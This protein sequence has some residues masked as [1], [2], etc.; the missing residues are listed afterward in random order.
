MAKFTA[1]A[2]ALLMLPAVLAAG[3]TPGLF[4]SYVSLSIELIGFPQWAGTK[5]NRNEFSNNLID[6]LVKAQE[7]PLVVR[8]GGNSADRAIFDAS[9]TTPT[10][11]SCKNADPGA[12]QCIGP[13]F[14]D[15]Y[16]A[17]PA[18]TRYSHGF[19]LATWNSS[20]FNTLRETV[21]LACR[22]LR[23]QLAYFEV[24]NEPDLYIGSRRPQ[25]YSVAQYVSEWSNATARFE[26]YLREACPDLVVAASDSNSNSNSNS[27][28]NNIKYMFP[29]VSSPRSKLRVPDII[30]AANAAAGGHDDDASIRRVTQV[31]VHN[32]M[33]GATQPGVTLQATLMNHTA[34]AASI[35]RHVAYAA[36]IGGLTPA[37]Y[38]IGEHNS[39]YGGGAA[40]LSD[41]FGAA[42][43]GMEFSLCAAS[44]GVI[45]RLHFHQSVGSPYAAWS[46]VAPL[47]TKPPYYG[48][49]AA[50]TF[51]AGADGIQVKT[52]ALGG[53]AD[54]GSDISSS[55][56]SD[57]DVDSAYGAYINGELRRLAVLNLREHDDGSASATQGSRRRGSK[58]HTIRVA[59]RSNWVVKRLTAPG[60]RD[61]GN[62]T[63]NGFAYE[64]ASNG[65]PVRVAGR[66]TDERVRADGRGGVSVT[67]AD[68]E[69]VVMIRT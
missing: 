41:V 62:I 45:K 54:D 25:D 5:D 60:A 10:A 53:D 27:N 40:G 15:S 9:L 12:W 20:G 16:G 59:P 31:S 51:L 32:Y 6:N 23:G 35:G 38:V 69:A 13:S 49:L 55:S 24:G 44:T 1:T 56:G 19:N 63:F 14:F 21:P 2:T 29:S 48:K 65:K 22:A 18:G 33:G 52:L 8:V 66:T 39:L 34:V 46:P 7:S 37:D 42:L 67:V 30:S 26:A 57:K 11:G 28:N 4:S 47:Q 3:Q 50:G 43:W 61:R 58:K 36:S 68:S 17:L 64:A